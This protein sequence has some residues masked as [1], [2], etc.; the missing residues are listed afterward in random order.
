[1]RRLAI[2]ALAVLSLLPAGCGGDGGGRGERLVVAAAAS[3][4]EALT[5]CSARFPADVRLSFAGSDEIAAQIRRGV[6]PDVYAAANTQLPR[7]L[8]AEGR[9]REPVEFAGNELVLG[10]PAGSS[11]RSVADLARPGL[12]LAIGAPSVPVGA[13]TRA[14][15]GRL[16]A[17]QRRAI[18][19]AVRSEEPDVK[20][21]VGK[22]TQGAVDAGFVYRS[23]VTATDGR[24]RAVALPARLRP[25]VTYG[26]GVVVGAR[27]PELARRYVE[28]LRSGPC[29]QSL[30]QAGLGPP[31]R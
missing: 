4:R 31:P 7:A 10:L 5:A 9:L 2:A 3:L 27:Q 8:A 13:Y 28:G 15:L 19:A 29:A 11:V 25:R 23:D 14:V 18:L 17:A 26:A 6:K 30:R 1:M 16:P 21:V 20:G 12:A 24:L 22:L